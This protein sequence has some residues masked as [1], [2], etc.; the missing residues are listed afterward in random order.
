VI[1]KVINCLVYSIEFSWRRCKL[2]SSILARVTEYHF[3]E[4]ELFL[5]LPEFSPLTDEVKLD[6]RRNQHYFPLAF[7]YFRDISIVA[8]FIA[9]VDMKS[10]EVRSIPN[11]NLVVI[12]GLLSRITRLSRSIC[13]LGQERRDKEA[14]LI[15]SRS[16]IETTIIIRWFLKNDVDRRIDKYIRSGVRA[17][18]KLY[19]LINSNI[20]ERGSIIKIEER[21]LRSIKRTLGSVDLD[22]ENIELCTLPDMKVMLNEVGED[23]QY[24]F[25]QTIPSASVHGKWS[26]IYLHYLKDLEGQLLPKDT[27]EEAED[28]IYLQLTILICLALVDVS[29]YLIFESKSLSLLLEYLDEVYK[30]ALFMAQDTASDKFIDSEVTR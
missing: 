16:V 12:R 19:D 5:N 15:L 7:E 27:E 14:I 21:M 30:N 18:K 28:I 20:E 26:D 11:K 10:K 2:I 13:R 17:E 4:D 22:I 29:K 1:L 3:M 9:C 25:L 6:A 23:N 24:L 8:F